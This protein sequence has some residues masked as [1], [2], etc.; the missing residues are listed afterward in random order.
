MTLVETVNLEER[1]PMVGRATDL[2]S[3]SIDTVHFRVVGVTGI[4]KSVR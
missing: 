4:T 3:P 2:G 1:I